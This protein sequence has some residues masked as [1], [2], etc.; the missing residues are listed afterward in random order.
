MTSNITQKDA[1]EL[2]DLYFEQEYIAYS[3]QYKSFEDFIE[4]YIPDILTKSENVFFE[5]IT[6]KYVIK[7]LFEFSDITIKPPMTETDEKIIYPKD[8]RINKL[9][10]ASKLTATVKQVQHIINILTNEKEI[11]VNKV[12]VNVPIARIPIMTKSKYCN[13]YLKPD[14]SKN[15]CS[16]DPGANFIING[17]EKVILSVEKMIDNYPIV[18]VK[19]DQNKKIYTTQ[20]NSM[21][22]NKFESSHKSFTL[23]MKK[24]DSIMVVLPNFKEF[25]VF[26]LMKVLG[27]DNDKDILQSII[28]DLNDTEMRQQIEPALL[29]YQKTPMKREEA[30]ESLINSI[31]TNKFYSESNPEMRLKQ[32]RKHLMKILSED[33]LPHITS[34]TKDKDIN[35]LRKAH[36]IGYILH[37]MIKVIIQDE[38][39]PD[40]K[41]NGDD[42][43]SFKNK[44]IE[45]P[46]VLLAQLF[47]QYFNKL[48][49]D[50]NKAFKNSNTSHE[51]PINIISRIK[52]KTI[53]QGLRQALA[54]GNW[55]AK[56]KKGIAQMLAR[57]SRLQTITYLRRVITPNIDSSKNK[58]TGPRHLHN[59]QFGFFDPMETPEG[60]KTGLVKNLT[61]MASITCVDR[62]SNEVLLKYL[63]SVVIRLEDINNMHIKNQIKVFFNGNWLGFINK[64]DLTTIY[65]KLEHM[66]QKE[67]SYDVE[68]TK[69]IAE[70]ELRIESGAG[71]L[72][73]PLLK[74]ENNEI[75]YKTSMLKDIKTWQELLL[76][77]PN[78]IEYIGVDKCIYNIVLADD[79]K[80]V[81]EQKEIMLNP[82]IKSKEELKELI[83]L[84]RY[85]R[86]VYKEITHCEFHPCMQYGMVSGNI[87]FF[88][89][90]HSPRGIYQYSQAKQAISVPTSDYRE[91]TDITYTLYYPQQPVVTTL[92][93]R[94]TGMNALPAGENVV[95][96]IA[97]F[98]G[99]NQ[100]DSLIINKSS[101]NRGK[102]RAMSLKK[103]SDEL[104]KNPSSPQGE[105]FTKPDRN[106]V[107][108]MKDGNYDKLNEKGFIKENTEIV[109]GDAIIGKI[110]PTQST[111]PN[112]KK[113]RDSSTIFKSTIPGY[114]NKV[115]SDIYNDGD[116]E[117]VN[118]TVR[119]ERIPKIGD[120]FSTRHGQ[121]GTCGILVSE[122]DMPF[123]ING[124]RPDIIMN[125]NALPKR[126][127]IG[128]LI[129]ALCA[130]YGIIMGE[131]FDGT[132]FQ[133]LD[134]NEIIELLKK[135]NG[136]INEVMYNAFTGEQIETEIYCCPCYYQRLKHMVD[137]KVHARAY[138]IVQTLVR[139]PTEGRAKE[140]GLRFGEMERDA[141][142]AHGASMLLNDRLKDSS[143][144]TL[145][146]ICD[147]CGTIASKLKGRDIYYCS[148]CSNTS[149]IS[150]VSVPYAMKLLFQELMSIN[151]FPGI[152]TNNS[153][154]Q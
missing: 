154:K 136:T 39:E 108:G 119:S 13:L 134:M 93:N 57:L 153:I 106:R 6:E 149:H 151:I 99:Y 123:T 79:I 94:Y 45:T 83:R 20:V 92:G 75:L 69:L 76:K 88:N 135:K 46:G 19:K 59:T 44:R 110:V 116:Y 150:A 54:T 118:M 58:M 120:K 152:I 23:R 89:S 15:E 145:L 29:E 67:I 104:N 128:Q 143:D 112:D 51:T 124:L 38:K 2:L 139:Q 109:N 84:N 126:M 102:F 103:Y 107:S 35:M 147:S 64:T 111:D 48:L 95:W 24:K 142:L 140:G 77:Y 12:E 148:G 50:C 122:E 87:P 90:N 115:Y 137:D 31:K 25:S 16:F 81:K 22:N 68:I 34:E 146:Y 26:T 47:H 52:P 42:R 91:R 21:T 100:E 127:T 60:G 131:M 73:R 98:T 55:G 40:G 5:E 9:T 82:I 125:P 80:T 53:E 66:K 43:D 101:V 41:D 114:I 85:G 30:I 74:V 130:K 11:K 4:V 62:H 96:A 17:N 105:I 133:D 1:K 49:K 70:R 65:N 97:N 78:I 7:Y 113:Y 86:M 141:V 28:Y 138:G 32:K 132:P 71:R 144:I 36:Y 56:N 37:R 3:H 27:L 117:I 63:N 8:A 10:Y 14:A 33:I 72:V 61:M 121:K 18:S 129:E